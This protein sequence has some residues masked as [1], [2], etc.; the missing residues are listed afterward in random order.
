MRNATNRYL[1]RLSEA[2]PWEG[3]PA[4]DYR[5]SK[6]LG[7]SHGAVS[8]W[9]A[10]GGGFDVKTCWKVAE[11]LKIEPAE[12]IAAV[13][14]DR[15]KNDS[16]RDF[17]GGQLRRMGVAAGVGLCIMHTALFSGDGHASTVSGRFAVSTEIYI[18]RLRA[19]LARLAGNLISP[20]GLLG[21]V[22]A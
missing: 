9:R 20:I 2:F 6:M 15:A 21:A 16:D 19:W 18:T 22:P 10:D 1:D 7:V 3:R 11:L 5:I 12:V 8:R 4:T 17:W 14:K 13:E